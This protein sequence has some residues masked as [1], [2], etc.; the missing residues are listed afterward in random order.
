MFKTAHPRFCRLSVALAHPQYGPLQPCRSGCVPRLAEGTEGPAR[1]RD[2]GVWHHVL[3]LPRA[4]PLPPHPPPRC[5]LRLGR[6][7]VRCAQQ[8]RVLAGL[9]V[10]IGRLCV[11]VAG[12]HFRRWDWMWSQ[13]RTFDDGNGCGRRCALSTMGI[14]V[15]GRAGANREGTMCL[16]PCSAGGPCVSVQPRPSLVGHCR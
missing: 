12:A 1:A 13:V 9:R 11:V 14:D 10:G 8:G 2:G 6:A 5:H 15:D 4:A 7:G 3:H 16:Y